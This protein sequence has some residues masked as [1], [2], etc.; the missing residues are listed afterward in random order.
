MLFKGKKTLNKT[1][2]KVFLVKA[3]SYSQLRNVKQK[4]LG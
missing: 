3:F 2:A 1:L 4:Y